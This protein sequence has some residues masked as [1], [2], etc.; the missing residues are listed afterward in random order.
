[1]TAVA[2]TPPDR[3][4]LSIVLGGEARRILGNPLDRELERE[5]PHPPNRNG[6]SERR[7]RGQKGSRLRR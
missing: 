3:E 5:L 2:G 4:G 7:A 1:M 6:R